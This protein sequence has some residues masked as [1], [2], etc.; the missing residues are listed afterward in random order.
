MVLVFAEATNGKFKKA[1]HEAI[2]YGTKTAAAM[3]TECVALT[4]G[5]VENAGDLGRFGATKVYNV[6]SD[7]TATFDSGVYA[8]A[9]AEAAKQLGA[10]VIVMIHDST[11]KSVMGRVAA[12]LDAG[13]APGVNSVP[14]VSGGGLTVRKS[15]FSGK[16]FAEV[17]ITSEYKVISVAGNSIP[18]EETGAAATV[19]SLDLALPA[20][21]TKVLET[22][23][24]TGRIPLPEAELVVSGGRGLKGPENWNVIEDLA[25]ALGATTACSRPVADVDW[26]PHHEHVGQT[27]VAIRPNLY[28][29]AGISGAIQH[30]AGVNN[31]KTIVVINKDPE[32]PFFKAADYGVVGDLFEVLPKLTEAVKAYKAS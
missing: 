24:A 17:E 20:S 12:R 25:E 27:G 8:A 29:A 21:R 32:A 7:A 4:I 23:R 2:T 31:S 9:I 10:K 18:V 3:G 22:Q 16:A 5:Q 14:T 19:E 26:R 28:I 1:A 6:N 13:S 11:G 15:V 30:L